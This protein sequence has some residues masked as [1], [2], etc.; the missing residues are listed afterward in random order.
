MELRNQTSGLTAG[1]FAD[2]SGIQTCHNARDPKKTKKSVMSV[3]QKRRMQELS[4]PSSQPD[5]YYMERLRN[6][7]HDSRS[8]YAKHLRNWYEHFPPETILIVDYRD[9]ESDPRGT[10][11]KIVQHIG[12][13]EEEA[14]KYVES[15]DDRVLGQRVNAATSDQLRIDDST[16]SIKSSQPSSSDYFLSQRPN[17]KRQMQK[18]LQHHAIEFNA[19][20]KE[21]GYLWRL[22]EYDGNGREMT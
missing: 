5:S 3:A 10:L 1:S 11:S 22:D 15:L 2:G 14:R 6:A 12:L 8:N 21:K 7:T 13:H 9:I 4:S 17:L 18:Y 19:L 16:A 20:L